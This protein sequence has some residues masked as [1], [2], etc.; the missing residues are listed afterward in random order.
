MFKKSLI[1]ND[2]QYE[3]NNSLIAQNM[4][5]HEVDIGNK[6]PE[7]CLHC[8]N[9]LITKRVKNSFCCKGCYS[10]YYFLKSHD[11]NKYYE[12]MKLVGK[13]PTQ[14]DEVNDSHF[15]I[16]RD[17]SLNSIFKIKDEKWGFFVPEVKCAACIWLIEKILSRD[18]NI[19]GVS[20]SLLE[21]TV[22]FSFKNENE[23]SLEQTARLL[24]SAGYDVLPLPF[25]SSK[26]FRSKYEKERIKDIA[27]AGFAFGN[28]MI[29]AASSYFGLYFGIETH[30][31][32]L[33]IILSMII[34]VPTVV[35]AGRSFF[36]NSVR[37]LKNKI[38]HIDMTISF[39]LIVSLIVSIYET[40]MN[41][42]KVYYD[43]ITGLIFLLLVGRYFHE[44]SINKAKELG[45]S[46]KNILPTEAYTI[47]KGD[48][49]IV[50]IGKEFL[51]DGRIIEG[52]TEVNEAS[53]S[54]EEYP[55]VKKVSDFVL[56]GSQNIL[57]P[58]KII[59]EKTGTETWISSLENLIGAAKSRKS[60]IES[61]MEKIL[62]HF[63]YF[64][65]F[66][67]FIASF[68]WYFID[69]T[70]A[71][72]VFV[73]ILIISCPCAL[74]LATPLAMSSALKKLWEN[75]VIVKSSETIETISK[76]NTLI[77]DKTGTLTEGNLNI[78]NHICL[79]KD[80]FALKS[81]E[82]EEILNAI[83]QITKHSLHLV[84]KAI[85][86]KYLKS[87]LNISLT[88]IE[89]Y[90]G[91]GM[92]A[93]L[94]GIEIR[95]GKA[96]FVGLKEDNSSSEFCTYAKYEQ[97]FF[98][99]I[100]SETIRVD[101]KEFIQYLDKR[102]IESYILSGDRKESVRKIA[103]A[104]NVKAENC[105]SSLLPFE[106]LE[107]LE[108]LQKSGRYVMA[109]GDGVNDAAMLAKAHVGIAAHGGVDIALHSS[110]LF[111]RKHEMSL[112]KKTFEYSKYVKRTLI[113]LFSVSL[114]Y[115]GIVV[116]L[117]SL[118]FVNPLFAALFM[119]F[120]SLTVYFIVLFRKGNK[121]WRL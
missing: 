96:S 118:G 4:N 33:F 102:N 94:N 91:K 87:E 24:I 21:R 115:N 71:L 47:K 20:V 46:I 19:Y 100:L 53:L 76:I 14:V 22:S 84:S 28:V 86:K 29:F 105:F 48:I 5:D 68:V 66:S 73:A 72:D 78:I 93:F 116:I 92:L 107:Y 80:K 45:E 67:S 56:A 26:E 77:F 112:L 61:V 99:F 30:I 44:K 27:V 16:F 113:I 63:T 11:L 82:E 12:I 39:A 18:S 42:G 13:H 51:A 41:S 103:E 25:L 119:P 83:A 95:I 114:F 49:L 15:L 109:I 101:A 40:I 79:N 59:A 120:S 74:A 88:D 60:H 117:A 3:Q 110:D 43:T 34:T 50:P 121:I 52:E 106:K 70:Q 104:L 1:K 32:K 2:S 58:V 69:K 75:G 90:A 36:I 89:E 38:V 9:S 97:F 111:L 65:I 108:S 7:L 62:P 64:T 8:Q 55:V 81:P 23:K 57:K 6:L 98:K 54:G 10:V 35:Y 17:E 85:T 37:A 31:N